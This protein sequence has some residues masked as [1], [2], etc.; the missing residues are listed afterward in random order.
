MS[1]T[2]SQLSSAQKQFVTENYYLYHE[3]QRRAESVD[4]VAQTRVF[5]VTCSSNDFPTQNLHQK[6]LQL[7]GRGDACV[8]IE[9]LAPGLTVQKNY[10][11]AFYEYP[12]SIEI[13][14]C[15]SRGMQDVKKYIEFSNVRYRLYRA[16]CHIW[17]GCEKKMRECANRLNQLYDQSKVQVE[18]DGI[19]LDQVSYCRLKDSLCQS[20]YNNAE[21]ETAFF[22]A[23][24][25]WTQYAQREHFILNGFYNVP[26]NVDTLL[27]TITK[28]C[29]EFQKVFVLLGET[30]CSL[31]T[32]FFESLKTKGLNSLMLIPKLKS[33]QYPELRELGVNS[34]FPVRSL[35][36]KC[37]D[38]E[39]IIHY[40][41]LFNS[42]LDSAIADC[43]L[44]APDYIKG[45]ITLDVTTPKTTI[46]PAGTKIAFPANHDNMVQF[47]QLR[48]EQKSKLFLAINALVSGKKCFVESI[49]TEGKITESYTVLNR[50]FTL[51]LESERELKITLRKFQY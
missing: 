18:N 30:H 29:N 16:Q 13:K 38:V 10:C 31:E 35:K 9:A 12:D 39:K 40:E 32:S 5:L 36:I 26:M 1:L 7:Y 44:P 37:S 8:L 4:A 3:P 24:N 23:E 22:E 47:T 34:L 15:D 45:V 2:S 43:A 49:E 28:V 27:T 11:E 46:V 33:T 21:F 14:G 17:N 50:R 19:R 51:L 41:E 20:D 48:Q 42:F 6:L 25:S